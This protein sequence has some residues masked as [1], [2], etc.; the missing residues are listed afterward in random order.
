MLTGSLR[1][2][3]QYPFLSFTQ[4]Q[5]ELGIGSGVGLREEE[6]RKG[7]RGGYYSDVS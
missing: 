1:T 4:S 2:L 7:E 5:A 6:Q 3:A